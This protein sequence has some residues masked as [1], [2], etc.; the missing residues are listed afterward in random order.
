MI[1]WIT[2][3][4]VATALTYTI[5]TYNS[6]I[7]LENRVDNAW[8]QIR[9]QLK[10]RSDLIPNLV[11]TAERYAEH[12]KDV[13]KA[14]SEARSKLQAASTPHENAEASEAL[15]ASLGKLFAVAE[16]YPDLKADTQY[17]QVQEELS[18]TE[19]KIAYARQHYND[20]TTV[21]NTRIESFPSNIIA[22]LFSFAQRELFQ[23]ADEALDNLDL[24]YS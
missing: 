14:V 19:N 17:R 10:R 22:A 23:L 6:L 7:S 11:E 8:S 20:I 1:T 24:D 3:G 16:D 18:S 12:E 13:F 15:S 5:Y 2:L 9:V 4:I 21:Y